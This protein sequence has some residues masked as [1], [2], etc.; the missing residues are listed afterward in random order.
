MSDAL[1]LLDQVTKVFPMGDLEVR[2]LDRV[3]IAIASGEYVGVMG[4]SGSGKTTLMDILGGLS[5]PS[6]GTYRFE[7]HNVEELDDRALAE[8]RGGRIGFIFQTFNLLARLTA[9]ENVELP[10]LYRAVPRSECRRRAL[11]LLAQVGLEHRAGHRP[12]E[13]SGG[14]RQRVAIARALA[15]RPSLILADEPTGNLDTTTGNSILELIDELHRGG[16]T[17]VLVTHDP[18]VAERVGRI[19]RLRDGTIESDQSR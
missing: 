19:V 10:M 9:V 11:D 1:I 13:L 15:N 18:H 14:Q 7:G 6:S 5:R 2:A 8:V 3:S 4:P 17:I 16:Q 12:G